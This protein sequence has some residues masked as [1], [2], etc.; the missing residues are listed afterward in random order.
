L[1]TAV[2]TAAEVGTH[3][4]PSVDPLTVDPA[5]AEMQAE[6]HRSR[7]ARF[8]VA[9]VLGLLLPAFFTL[10]VSRRHRRNGGYPRGISLEVTETELRIW[11]RGYGSRV[12]IRDAVVEERLVDVYAGRLG[13]W[14]QVRLRLRTRHQDI[15]IAAPA[16]AG[17]ERRLRLEGGE[18]DC[19]EFERKDY[20]AAKSEVLTRANPTP[21]K[22]GAALV[23]PSLPPS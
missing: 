19:V 6:L 1:G 10:L 5:T 13:A 14:R 4:P 11:G 8:E 16:A 20:D 2:V 23:K 7:L 3:T 18:A 9:I 22:M 21:E 17:D 12:T 15:E